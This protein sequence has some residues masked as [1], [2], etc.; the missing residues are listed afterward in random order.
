MNVLNIIIVMNDFDLALH[1][2]QTL[3][4]PSINQLYFS[5]LVV[6]VHM[7]D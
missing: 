1:C 6:N 3:M 5:A 7:T 2:K 4:T